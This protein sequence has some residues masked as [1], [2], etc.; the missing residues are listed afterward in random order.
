MSQLQQ[1]EKVAITLQDDDVLKPPVPLANCGKVE[2]QSLT[3]ES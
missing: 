1:R 3:S 2:K